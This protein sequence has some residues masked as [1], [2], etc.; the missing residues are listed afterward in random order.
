MGTQNTEL[1]GPDLTEGI[2]LSELGEG[3]PMLAHA[4]GEALVVV[5][6]KDQVFVM[7]ASCTHYGGPLAE[8]LV[9]DGTIRCPWHH[10]CFSLETG[11]AIGAPALSP[12]PCYGVVQR[13]TRV[14]IGEKRE[15]PVRSLSDGSLPK[16]VV[17]V[18]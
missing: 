9:V 6:R 17:V 13:G 2:E 3:K 4:R 11:E 7:G 5:R 12:L 10:A 8:G 18:G 1:K 15:P 14:S 16:S